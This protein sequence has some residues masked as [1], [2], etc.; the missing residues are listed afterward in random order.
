[1][2]EEERVGGI[3]RLGLTHTLPRVA[4]LVKN[5]PEILGSNLG[6]EDPIEKG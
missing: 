5:P 2:G 4:Q 6:C 1:M 3:G